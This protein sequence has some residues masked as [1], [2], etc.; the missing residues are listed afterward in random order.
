MKKLIY[1]L[2]FIG[3]SGYS[4]GFDGFLLASRQQF[5]NEVGG[6]PIELYTQ[7]D[8]ADTV[9][10]TN[11]RGAGWF[12]DSGGS[13]TL[14]SVV[15]GYS[16]T[17]ALKLDLA[18]DYER[19]GITFEGL[20]NTKFYDFSVAIKSDNGFGAASTGFII[21]NGDS[22]AAANILGITT[23]YVVRTTTAK[24]LGTTLTFLFYPTDGDTS[25][26]NSLTFDSISLKVAPTLHQ[27][28]KIGTVADV[29][30]T[31]DSTVPTL[32][33]GTPPSGVYR[34]CVVGFSIEHGGTV[35]T[36]SDIT[37]GGV[38]ADEIITQSVGT[39]AYCVIYLARFNE[40]SI[41]ASGGGSLGVSFTGVFT[42]S[43]LSY[44]FYENT[45]QGNFAQ[46][47][48][49]T[50]NTTTPNPITSVDISASEKSLVVA[51]AGIGTNTGTATWG[52]TNPLTEQTESNCDT[53]GHSGTFADREV[54]VAE[55]VGVRCTW[56]TQ[57]RATI[58]SAEILGATYFDG[59]LTNL[60]NF[61]NAASS[62][63]SNLTTSWSGS[64][65]FFIY[66][67]ASTDTA[68]GDNYAIQLYTRSTGS[69]TAFVSHTL[70]ALTIG[71]PYRATIRCRNFCAQ[72]NLTAVFFNWSG[73][74]AT[75]Y[76]ATNIPSTWTEVEVLFTPTVANP[77]MKLY[78]HYNSTGRTLGDI[79]EIS[80]IIISEI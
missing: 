40:A 7:G 42:S 5:E 45:S 11:T 46:T 34:T 28:T 72:G 62:N 31:V 44:A 23:S 35:P 76:P 79:F 1:I 75:T 63:D 47:L 36:I 52:G 25:Y 65:T 20:D 41:V 78:P 54:T 4:Q 61:D 71:V 30:E 67:V 43:V 17:Y 13:T 73:V 14:T 60:Y 16:G 49:G 48:S 74:S 8:A 18:G 51:I 66:S 58:I 69:S 38:S 27:A 80:S 33:V 3:L 22:P 21:V 55:T 26:T 57:N 37:M 15:D 68:L 59:G 12:N 19:W 70:P 32:S 6:G 53:G 24:P 64:S 9:T 56:T 10:E 29:C 2:L 39:A 50:T 77:T